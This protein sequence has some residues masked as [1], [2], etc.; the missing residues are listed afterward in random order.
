MTSNYN[1]INN[2]TTKYNQ[3]TN[4]NTN[5]NRNNVIFITKDINITYSDN[6]NIYIVTGIKKNITIT[7][8]SI[9]I[10]SFSNNNNIINYTIIN[11]SSDIVHI[12][13]DTNNLI[14]NSHLLPKKYENISNNIFML[15]KN[16]LC[17]LYINNNYD[18][19]YV[20]LALHS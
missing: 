3:N 11:N 10:K 16:R 8:P 14:F 1:S 17:N 2:N 19:N 4:I 6:N 18:N 7:L 20:W 12:I 5:S 9:S 13:S 15:E